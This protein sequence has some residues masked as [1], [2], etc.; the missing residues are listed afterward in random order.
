V[1]GPSTRKLTRDDKKRVFLNAFTP[2]LDI[3][4]PTIEANMKLYYT[5]KSHYARKV[6]ILIDALDLPVALV[7]IQDVTGQSA[8]LFA[9]NPMMKVP[10]LTDGEVAVFESDHIAQYLVRRFDTEDRFQVLTTDPHQLN[11]RAVMNG[12]MAAEVEVIL[13][14]RTGLDTQGVKR[15]D[16]HREVVNQGMGWLESNA[17]LLAEQP[18]YNGFHLVSLWDHLV[19]YGQYSLDYPSLNRRYQQLSQL[20]FVAQSSPL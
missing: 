16:K 5:P 1:G 19:L 9:D 6:R 14:E 13:A 17:G 12:V 4:T 7:D 3:L 15:F 11:L 20:D 8:Q 2:Q 18:T 10:T